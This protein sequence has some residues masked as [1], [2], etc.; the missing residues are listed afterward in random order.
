MKLSYN[1]RI[2]KYVCIYLWLT[3]FFYLTLPL[4]RDEDR[5]METLTMMF[6][7]F[8]SVFFYKGCESE[9]IEFIHER[10]EPDF[11]V[12]SLKN[13]A[14]ILIILIGIQYMYLLDL[15]RSGLANLS[16]SMGEA[17]AE[18]LG[19]EISGNSFWG[20][21]YVLAS[22]FR[23]FLIV[24]C[25][26]FFDE[27]NKTNRILFFLFL[28]LIVA[29]TIGQGVQVGL[30]NLSV[31]LIVPLF[32]KK[33]KQKKLYQIKRYVVVAFL[34]FVVFFIV[35]QY[36]RAEVY[37]SDLTSMIT[38][39]DNIYFM[40]FGEKVGAGIIR[41]LSYLSH[42]YRGLNY[43]LQLPFEW[44][45]GYGGS[46]ALNEYLTQYLHFTSKFEDAYPMRVFNVFG[47]DCQM[48]WPTAFA[49]W[50]SDFSFP[51]V[52]ILMYFIGK[53]TCI[54]FKD[55]YYNSNIFAITFFCVLVIMIIFMPMNNQVLQARDSLV[56]TTVLFCVWFKTRKKFNF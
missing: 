39:D 9:T 4:E 19:A 23:V 31:Y 2:G 40:I 22:P 52:V 51:G 20:Q 13:I 7:F 36:Q 42:G 43:S 11:R 14:I 18:R 53:L 25:T 37:G 5:L 17:Y 21:L 50:A 38:S 44:T 8:A 54:V 6:L 34:V 35:N 3:Y 41:F 12:L 1:L 30:G 15:I 55:A 27:I 49:W 47:Y 24:Y 46:R 45:Y 10:K 56:I 32:F 28:I 26:Y 33:L 48:A 16:T 29:Y